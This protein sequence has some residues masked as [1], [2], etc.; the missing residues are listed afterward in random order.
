MSG[1]GGGKTW[2]R[3]GRKTRFRIQIKCYDSHT[4]Q[5]ALVSLPPEEEDDALRRPSSGE[6]EPAGIKAAGP[7][8]MSASI[9][10]A[11]VI[12]LLAPRHPP[13]RA[14]Q[15]APDGRDSHSGGL[16]EERLPC[17]AHTHVPAPR[18]AASPD[19]VRRQG[20]EV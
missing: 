17:H 1:G 16:V 8:G 19:P 3:F 9:L 18:Q 11:S 10:N 7:P 4:S 12:S 14:R 6:P 2:T 5:F 13:A 20:A 15:R